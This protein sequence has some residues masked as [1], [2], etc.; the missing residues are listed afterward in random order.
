LPLYL[1][2]ARAIIDAGTIGQLSGLA[3]ID[4]KQIKYVYQRT[5]TA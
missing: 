4:V 5:G 3:I 1:A 2:R